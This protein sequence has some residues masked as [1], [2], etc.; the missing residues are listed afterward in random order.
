[1]IVFIE[2]RGSEGLN[3]VKVSINKRRRKQPF[4]HGM[5]EKD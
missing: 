2:L 1:M 3:Q 5:E 4:R